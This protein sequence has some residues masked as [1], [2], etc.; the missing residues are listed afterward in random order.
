MLGHSRA[1]VWAQFRTL[2]NFYSRGNVGSLVFT[3]VMS[4]LWYSM[5]VA[6]AVLIA[7]FLADPARREVSQRLLPGG[8]AVAFLYWQ[9]VPIVLTATGASLDMKRLAVYPVTHSQ[10][11]LL[12][13]LLRLTTGLEM[14]IVLAGAT[15]GLLLNPEIPKW[16][17]IGFL[18]FIAMNLL[19]AAGLRDLLGR[20]LAR[21]RI[22]EIAVFGLVLL[23]ALPQLM[24][25]GGVGAKLRPWMPRVEFLWW[26]WSVTG[27]IAAGQ[28]QWF[29]WPLLFFWTALAY[30][31]GRWQFDRG[32]RFD[33]EAAR[34]SSSRVGRAAGWADSIYRIPSLLFPDPLGALIEK[35]VR[36]L[37]R[38]P[39]FRLVFL[40]GFSFGLLIWLPLAF[41]SGLG[42]QSMMADNFLTFVTVYA[43][44]LL[45]EVTFWNAFGFDRSA[46]QVYF[47]TPVKASTVLI[48]KNITAAFFVLLEITAVALVC[49]ALRMPVTIGKLGEAYA[50]TLVLALY[51]MAIGNIGSTYYPRPVNPAQSWR[52]ASAGRFQALLLLIYPVVSLPIALAYLARFAFESNWAFYSVLLFAAALGGVIYWVAMDSAIS[53]AEGRKEKLVSALS[54]GEGPV[55]A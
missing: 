10:L 55:S 14:V 45:G 47:V 30:A 44:M 17:P 25:V 12:E 41:G 35:E 6:A 20:V 39:R 49:M 50:V 22:R 43:L 16:A 18:P 37:C 46:V 1:I 33:A 51:L 54:Q 19:L 34:A 3:V 29:D 52:A 8:L 21:K 9:V 23:M 28:P 5:C 4:V 40:M 32:F 31:F 53:A 38:A 2:R 36:F 26:P 7:I 48:A 11:F 15:V 27:H 13:V 24:L 42:T